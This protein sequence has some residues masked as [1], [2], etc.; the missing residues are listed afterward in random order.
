MRKIF[1][2]LFPLLSGC[3]SLAFLQDAN[4]LQPAKIQGT[5]GITYIGDY[6]PLA[7]CS[8]RVGVFENFDIGMKFG[9]N[10]VNRKINESNS[11]TD[12][13]WAIHNINARY[14]FISNPVR[15][16]AGIGLSNYVLGSY[17]SN[18]SDVYVLTLEPS[19]LVGQTNWYFAIRPYYSTGDGII[20]HVSNPLIF[21]RDTWSTYAFTVGG[22][23]PVA[24]SRILLELNY[25]KF[26]NNQTVLLPAIGIQTNL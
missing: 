8:G 23:I 13:E 21:E 16:I 5:M 17:P 22:S 3:N 25:F 12:F 4:V 7:E 6:G 10:V 24:K 9:M 20:N 1:I 15:I 26:I 11:E 14:Q 2:I 19:I 18:G